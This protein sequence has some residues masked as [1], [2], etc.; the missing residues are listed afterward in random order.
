M[1]TQAQA[2]Q[3]TCPGSLCHHVQ[4]WKH[5]DSGI[6]ALSWSQVEVTLDEP[7]MEKDLSD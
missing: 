2:E 5:A 7:P 4:T 6:G 3:V 1:G